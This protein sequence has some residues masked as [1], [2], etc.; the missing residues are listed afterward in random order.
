[1]KN[2][3]I[4]LFFLL[5]LQGALAEFPYRKY[6]EGQTLVYKMRAIND[7]RHYEV[8][9][10]HKVKKNGDAFYEEVIWKSLVYEGKEIDLGP[11]KDFRQIS[12]SSKR[13]PQ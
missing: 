6:V 13:E 10:H 11:L 3:I 5:T 1:M 7:G 12:L 2:L 9:S 8:I 4:I